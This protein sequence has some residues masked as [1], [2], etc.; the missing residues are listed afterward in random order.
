M[1]T[2]KFVRMAEGTREDYALLERYETEFAQGLADRVLDRFRALRK[3]F[4]GH[5]IDRFDH[6]LQTA[7]RAQRDGADEETVV[8][9]LLHD[10]GDL[11]APANHADYAAAILEPYVSEANHW[12]VRHHGIFQLYYYGHHVG[13]ERNERE[14]YRGHPHFERTAAF[15]EKWDQSSFDPGYETMPLAAFEPLVH[16]I[17]ARQPFAA[18]G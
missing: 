12:V 2:V 3:S 13:A 14:K 9:A 6:S 8:C 17:F 4:S 18:C 15:C 1:E 7:T 5:R 10:L 16:R 11:L